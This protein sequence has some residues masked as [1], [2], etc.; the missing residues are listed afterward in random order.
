MSKHI[1]TKEQEK[2]FKQAVS[3][4][5]KCKKLGLRIYAKQYNLVAYTK[6]ADDYA[7]ENCPLHLLPRVDNF[8]VIPHLNASSVLSDSGA[9][10][11]AVYI[12]QEDAD[13]YNPDD[14]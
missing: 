2:A 14:L 11:Y 13:K 5:K 9:D 7:D 8:G 6:E 4:L 3:A 12:S 1:A 10:D